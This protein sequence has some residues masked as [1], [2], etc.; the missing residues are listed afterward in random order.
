MGSA[1]TNPRRLSADCNGVGPNSEFD[2]AC[3]RNCWRSAIVGKCDRG[4]NLC[5][6]EGEF[7][8]QNSRF[9]IRDSKFKIQDSRFKIQDSK[10]K[11]QEKIQDSKGKIQDSRFKVQDS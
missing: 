7:K 11:I 8:I 9:K 10:F 4:R 3:S 5:H 2:I 6:A 1:W